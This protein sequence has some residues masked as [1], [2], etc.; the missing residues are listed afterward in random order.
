[1]SMEARRS[2]TDERL[3]PIG[4]VGQD[5]IADQ[6]ETVSNAE[7]ARI[8]RVSE[9]TLSR[10]V[11]AG[12]IRKPM[13]YRSRNRWPKAYLLQWLDE[14]FQQLVLA[15]PTS[16]PFRGTHRVR[17]VIQRRLSNWVPLAAA[18]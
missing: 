15:S 14:Q 9:R 2:R 1:M 5:Q 11:N 3:D 16:M 18:R 12:E 13:K 10:M 17:P 7:A 4:K 8:L 6:A